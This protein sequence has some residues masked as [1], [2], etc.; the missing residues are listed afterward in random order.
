VVQ[1]PT[2][3]P[4]AV[5]K[6]WWKFGQQV[7]AVHYCHLRGIAHRD[8]SPA[9]YSCTN[10][11]LQRQRSQ[12]LSGTIQL[13]SV[14]CRPVFCLLR[15]HPSTFP[16]IPKKSASVPVLCLITFVLPEHQ[17]ETDCQSCPESLRR[18]T[19]WTMPLFISQKW[20][21]TPSIDPQRA[22]ATAFPPA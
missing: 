1:H 3:R 21:P 22:P 15:T 4:P 9:T 18:T 2:L 14:R 20:S 6:A 13:K 5:E 7:S 19:R 11:M 8:L 16:L 10:L 12:E 17:P